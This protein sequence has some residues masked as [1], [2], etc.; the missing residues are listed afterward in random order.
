MVNIFLTRCIFNINFFSLYVDGR[1]IPTKVLQSNFVR[2]EA[3]R[4]YMQMH[5]GVGMAFR[6]EDNAKSYIAFGQGST[7]FMFDLTVNL[8]N[9]E[10]TE[11]TRRCSLCTEVHFGA[12]VANPITCFVHVEY[13]NC[14]ESDQERK[15]HSTTWFKIML[16]FQIVKILNKKLGSVFKGAYARKQE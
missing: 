13:D 16:T 9:A 7:V 3:M 4:S 2:P 10:H 11:P 6:D 14:I 12:P 8:P 5:S 15:N 1:Q